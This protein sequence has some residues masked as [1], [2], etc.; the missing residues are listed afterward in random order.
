VKIKELEIKNK[1]YIIFAFC[2]LL[3]NF[4]AGSWADSV[5]NENS[6]SPYSTQK[7]YKIGD[8]INVIVLESST[9]KNLAGTNT[10]VSDDLS[11]KFTHTIQRLA[12][13]IGTNNQ[14][15]AQI[16]NRYS[17]TGQTT[18]GS[19]VQARVSAWV[20]GVLPNG[21]LAIKG[22]HRVEV[23]TEVQEI[24]LTG[25]VRPKDISG[26]NTIYSYQVANAELAIKGT[27]TV[28]D[29][30]SPGWLTRIFNWLF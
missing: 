4:A 21:N 27:G 11:A 22:V 9:A 17:G 26:A 23:N 10:N 18:R 29:S 30:E 24:S 20:T 7:A 13:I 3:F 25:I 15:A 6:A 1:K 2:F 5:W 8:I 28:A 19:N 12:P 14:A 16:S